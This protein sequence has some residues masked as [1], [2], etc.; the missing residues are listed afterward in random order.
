MC[1]LY[2]RHVATRYA[3][4][5]D[6]RLTREKKGAGDQPPIFP[7]PSNCVAHPK[8]DATCMFI[9]AFQQSAVA[10]RVFYRLVLVHVQSAM[11]RAPESPP[12]SDKRPE[13][14]PR[15]A[16]R[17]VQWWRHSRVWG[18]ASCRPQRHYPGGAPYNKA[19]TAT[20]YEGRCFVSTPTILPRRDTFRER[21][22][23]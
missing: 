18:G 21:K 15:G 1:L 19:R 9:T 8:I 12:R 23:K 10:A 14:P 2:I 6:S 17:H 7:T 5:G 11:A 13:D 3:H 20:P 16:A 22:S 4:G